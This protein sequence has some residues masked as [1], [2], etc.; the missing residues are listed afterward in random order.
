M[1]VIKYRKIFYSL[2]VI[3]I[4]VSILAVVFWGLRPGIDFAGGSLLDVSFDG[5]APTLEETNQVLNNLNFKD[6]SVRSS[7]NGFIIRL[8]EISQTE[9]DNG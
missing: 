3:L 9:N 5:P 8:K 2:S 1:F 7:G 6:T 4:G